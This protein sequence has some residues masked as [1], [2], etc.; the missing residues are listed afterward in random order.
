MIFV[1][2]LKVLT[3]LIFF[4]KYQDMMCNMVLKG[5]KDFLDFINV[6]LT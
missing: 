4:E 6:I 2:N 3:S 5:K 1:S